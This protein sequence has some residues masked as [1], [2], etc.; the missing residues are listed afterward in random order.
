[1][2]EHCPTCGTDMP[3]MGPV[4]FAAEREARGL[5]KTA[6]AAE[7]GVARHVYDVA[8]RRGARPYPEPARAIAAYF[9][10]PVTEVFSGL[11]RCCG[12]V[13]VPLTQRDHRKVRAHALIDAADLGV[14]EG[15]RYH[16]L[17]NGYAAR[18]GP[19]TRTYMHRDLLGEIPEGLF[20]DHISRFKLDNR[21]SNLRLV[22]PAESSQNVPARAGAT[23]RFRGVSW[24]LRAQRW[25]AVARHGGK[26]AYIGAF[27][28]EVAA[29]IAVES[30]RR[31]HM[32]FAEPDPELLAGGWIYR[33]G[34]TAKTTT[35]SAADLVAMTGR[36]REELTHHYKGSA[37]A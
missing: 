18:T 2:T 29:A 4:D 5:S 35:G 37:A 26:S 7:I 6:F 25:A 10:R 27:A 30:Y 14:V 28:D 31:D 1:M 23:S 9:G 19:G 8:E 3:K 33:T 15:R 17:Q 34:R 12:L 16:L 20:V 11:L 22:T 32:P 36:G 24:D 13:G 21:R